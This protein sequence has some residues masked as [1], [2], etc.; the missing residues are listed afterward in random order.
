MNLLAFGFSS[1]RLNA[2]FSRKYLGLKSPA[3]KRINPMTESGGITFILSIKKQNLLSPVSPV[4]S[5]HS[6][7]I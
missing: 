2:M 3:V 6:Q 4:T 5:V 1:E 7:A